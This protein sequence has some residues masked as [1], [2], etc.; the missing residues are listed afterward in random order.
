SDRVIVP[1]DETHSMLLHRMAGNGVGRMPPVGTNDRDLAGE[2]LIAQWIADLARPKSAS[3]LLNLAARALVGTGADVLIPGFVISGAPRSVLVRAVGPT[4]GQF[5]VGGTLNAPVL[6]LYDST[7][8]VIA[9][10]TRWG[11]AANA[12]I[13]Q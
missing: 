1:G 9:A 10:N 13:V 3:R 7:S 8:R 5:G 11:T 2:S 12:A 4:L 6:S